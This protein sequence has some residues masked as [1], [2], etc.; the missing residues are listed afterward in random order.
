MCTFPRCSHQAVR[1]IKRN[2]ASRVL[3]ER[4]REL[5][6]I[7]ELLAFSSQQMVQM[8]A[9]RGRSAALRLCLRPSQSSPT[10]NGAADIPPKQLM[11]LVQVV[12]SLGRPVCLRTPFSMPWTLHWRV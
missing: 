10:T 8:P 5:E 6:A 11:Q 12:A 9:G 3:L 1:Y 7:F 4:F 2:S